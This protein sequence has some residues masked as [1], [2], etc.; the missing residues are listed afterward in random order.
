MTIP[1]PAPAPVSEPSARPSSS[2]S[3][4]V[5]I[6][7][8]AVVA[9]TALTGCGREVA[10]APVEPPPPPICQDLVDA[11]PETALA[12]GRRPTGEVGTAAWGEPPIV[13][14]C[15]VPRPAALTATSTLVEVN[16]IAWLPEELT[17]GTLFTVVEWP[18]ASTPVY[19]E[20][21]VPSAYRPPADVLADVS[22]AFATTR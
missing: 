4:A 17:N 22:G 10:V 13:L 3:A 5:A 2:R 14:R 20:I 19:V 7:A 12:A 8:L 15:G 6:A 9:A 18:D 11:L 1:P 21:A 16:T